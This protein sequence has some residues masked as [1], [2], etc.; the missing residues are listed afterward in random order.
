MGRT[1]W[2]LVVLGVLLSGCA[3]PVQPLPPVPTPAPTVVTP[4]QFPRDAGPHDAITEWW[5]YTGHLRTPD[6]SQEYGFEFTVFQG[7]RQGAPPGYMAHFAVTDVTHQTFS[8]QVRSVSGERAT[9]F[10]F[11]VQG[12]KLGSDGTAETID[13]AM[14]AGPGA[15]Q[16]YAVRLRLVDQKPPALHHGGFIDYGPA[17]GSYYYSRTR[18]GVLGE[19]RSGDASWQPVAGEAWMD[20]QWGNFVVSA[21]GWD[22]YSLQLADRSELMLYVL[23]A[24]SGETSA[25]YGSRVLPDGT[26]RD[27]DADAVRIEVTGRWT[28]LHTGADYPSGW[29]VSLPGQGI[30]LRVEPKVKDQELYVLGTSSSAPTYWEGAVSVEGTNGSS[31]SG[32][33]YVELTGYAQ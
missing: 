2:G 7:L 16:P 1:W 10:N 5:Y 24:P 11:D 28:S 3:R 22:W 18:I 12:W 14:Q 21:G 33:G 6:G 20:H 9:G 17:G 4:V 32:E 30:S 8:H 15:E 23:R 19:I 29:V 13:A 31:P 26:V 27:L 25:V